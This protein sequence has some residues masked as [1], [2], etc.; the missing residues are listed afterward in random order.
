[1]MH[2]PLNVKC[3]EA[4]LPVYCFLSALRIKKLRWEVQPLEY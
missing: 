1:M 3:M 4:T 2:G